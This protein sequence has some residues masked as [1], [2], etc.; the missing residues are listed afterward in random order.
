MYNIY[1]GKV[2]KVLSAK[3]L[4]EDNKFEIIKSFEFGIK[5]VEE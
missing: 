2:L 4:S 1:K 5:E 3:E